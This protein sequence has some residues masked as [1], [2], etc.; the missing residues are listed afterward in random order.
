MLNLCTQWQWQRRVHYFC[1]DIKVNWFSSHFNSWLIRDGHFQGW[2]GNTHCFSKVNVTTYSP[3]KLMYVIQCAC[4]WTQLY[5]SRLYA[6][7]P[8]RVSIVFLLGTSVSGLPLIWPIQPRLLGQPPTL[9]VWMCV[10]VTQ[11][12][13]EEERE[14]E[15]RASLHQFLICCSPNQGFRSN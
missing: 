14:R 2:P 11:T 1:T 7:L 15:S 3:R 9:W 13:R 6:D 5:S 4:V 8:G 10:F 12:G